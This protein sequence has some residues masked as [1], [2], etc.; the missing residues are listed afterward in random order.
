MTFLEQIWAGDKDL[1]DDATYALSRIASLAYNRRE[2]EAD[3][4]AR[5]R[6]KVPRHVLLAGLKDPDERIR[7][8][9]S[10]ALGYAGMDVVP[11]LVA[12]LSDP[13]PLVRLQ[14][15]RA[16]GFM[17]SEARPALGPLR[18]RLGD[19]DAEVRGAAEATINAILRP[20]R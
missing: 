18:E 19:I 4:Q 1:R 20:D 10:Q 14:A 5:A 3:E 16:L 6:V 13:S 11:D 2:G 8:G 12:A 17:A 9:A 15:S 7:A